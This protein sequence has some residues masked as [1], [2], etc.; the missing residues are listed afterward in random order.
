VDL[1]ARI[2][3]ARQ[4]H[5]AVQ[6]RER[7]EAAELHDRAMNARD[8]LSLSDTTLRMQADV[9]SSGEES[10][11]RIADLRRRVEN[12]SLTTDELIAKAAYKLLSGD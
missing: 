10:Q 8:K 2:K 4:K 11:S 1:S 3:N 5:L 6:G 7:L 12:A 9:A